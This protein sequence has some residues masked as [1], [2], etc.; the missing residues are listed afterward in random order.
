[1]C[2]KAVDLRCASRICTGTSYT[3]TSARARGGL[4]GKFGFLFNGRRCGGMEDRA[5]SRA[6]VLCHYQR[7]HEC[8]ARAVD[9]VAR[10]R[11]DIQWSVVVHLLASHTP[12]TVRLSVG[13]ELPAVITFRD[14]C[15]RGA[16]VWARVRALQYPL[17]SL[18]CGARW[19]KV[20]RVTPHTV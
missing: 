15:R 20:L 9:S 2:S 17:P 5:R 3:H 12:H 19:Q 13:A 6:L 4:R 16:R 1:M 18:R 10:L 7:D 8:S 11:A 14:T